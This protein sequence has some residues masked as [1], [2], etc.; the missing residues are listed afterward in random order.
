[1]RRQRKGALEAV[2]ARVELPQQ[3]RRGA[4][5]LAEQPPPFRLRPQHKT[6][7]VA[8]L[9]EALPGRPIPGVV[10][11][12]LSIGLRLQLFLGLVALLFVALCLGGSV[13]DEI[14]GV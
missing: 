10:T 13:A 8:Q 5:T 14:E 7:S 1:M 2:G 12:Q 11:C 3:K 9:K 4:E 6:G